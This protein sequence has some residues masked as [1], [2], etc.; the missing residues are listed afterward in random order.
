MARIEPI[1]IEAAEGKARELLDELVER[2]G[3]PGPMVRAMANAPALLRGYLDLTRAMKRT[4]IDRRIV[5]RINLAV[6]EWLNCDYC[7]VAHT[8]AARQLGV[9]DSEIR[10][11][12]QGTSSDPAIAAIVAFAQQVLAAPAE[13]GDAD[14]DRLHSHGYRD[15]QIAEVAGLVGLQLL[16]GAFNLIADI[17]AAADA[18][19]E[20]TPPSVVDELDH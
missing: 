11:A 18:L 20:L 9:P 2:G 6:H 17:H 10:L 19:T 14:I 15:E 1:P 13:I 4:H 3:E 8:R 5:E 12:R 16:T 7:L